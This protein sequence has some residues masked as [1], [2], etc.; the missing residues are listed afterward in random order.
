MPSIVAL[1]LDANFGT[2]P[3]TTLTVL[4]AML[5]PGALGPD[6]DLYWDPDSQLQYKQCLEAHA[7]APAFYRLAT[8]NTH[9]GGSGMPTSSDW[10]DL[11]GPGAATHPGRRDVRVGASH[12]VGGVL[13]HT[14]RRPLAS[15]TATQ[16]EMQ[17]AAMGRFAHLNAACDGAAKSVVS[18]N[19]AVQGDGQYAGG[20]G[21]DPAFMPHSTAWYRY[22]LK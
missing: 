18:G 4:E 17:C 21:T 6:P 7:P 2:Q 8:I 22:S 10:A 5:S 15:G 13:L 14:T 9:G 20:I 3:I 1:A 12:V 11:G 19:G 16:Q